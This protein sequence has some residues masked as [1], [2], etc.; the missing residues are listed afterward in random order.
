[1]KAKETKMQTSVTKKTVSMVLSVLISCAAIGDAQA[2][3]IRGSRSCGTWIKDRADTKW[4]ALAEQD[5][6]LGFLSG[7][8][9]YSSK[10]ILNG[11][12][13]ESIFLWV[14]NYCRANP[15][16]S[17]YHAGDELFD[18]LVKQKRL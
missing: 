12:D 15:L 3:A 7:M 14:D 8:A 11:T 5:W 10:D 6:L 2:S 18:E 16:K 4:L 9:F 13:N 17:L 1:M